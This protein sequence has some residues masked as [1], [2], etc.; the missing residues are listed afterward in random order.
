MKTQSKQK[1]NDKTINGKKTLFFNEKLISLV[2]CYDIIIKL[3]EFSES[4]EDYIAEMP[5][6]L[7]LLGL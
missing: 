4:S 3:S 6:K 5:V 7:G 1:W 2:S